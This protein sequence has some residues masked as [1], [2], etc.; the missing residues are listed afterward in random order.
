M[1]Q[2]D[3]RP[4]GDQIEGSF[5]AA[6]GNILFLEIDHELFSG[7]ILSLPLTQEGQLSF[8]VGLNA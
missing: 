2:S 6:S 8:L 4:T 3:V 5:P 7:V 1:A